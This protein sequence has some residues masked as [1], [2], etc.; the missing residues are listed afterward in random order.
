MLLMFIN[1]PNVCLVFFV[2]CQVFHKLTYVNIVIDNEKDV[3]INKIF[4][5]LENR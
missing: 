2:N 4:R 3:K 5:L 1:S